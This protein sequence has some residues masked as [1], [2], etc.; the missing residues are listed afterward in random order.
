MCRYFT[1][2]KDYDG[3]HCGFCSILKSQDQSV[4]PVWCILSEI[5]SIMNT[6]VAK[7]GFRFDPDQN[8]R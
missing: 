3:Q 1:L 6:S 8:R 7:I 5:T 4:N 2:F